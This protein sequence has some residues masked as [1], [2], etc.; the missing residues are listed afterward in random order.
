MPSSES[1]SPAAA[2]WPAHV[3]RPVK[4]AFLLQDFTMGGISQWIYT[5]CCELHRTNAGAFEFH[6]IATHGW[7]IQ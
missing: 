1:P 5:I 3:R 2:P 4:I 6:F 7:V